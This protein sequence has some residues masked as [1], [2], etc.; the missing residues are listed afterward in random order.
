MLKD[1]SIFF[2]NLYTGYFY[3]DELNIQS[4]M[5][6]YMLIMTSVLYIR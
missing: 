1:P 2:V 4:L 6:H 3:G 5:A